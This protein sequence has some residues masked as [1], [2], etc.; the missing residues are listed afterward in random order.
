MLFCLSIGAGGSVSLSE[1][2]SAHEV[3]HAVL[4]QGDHTASFLVVLALPVFGGLIGGVLAVRYRSRNRP[5]STDRLSH[6]LIGLLI[7]GLGV[8]SFLSAV[9]GHVWLSAAGVTVGVATALRFE[10]RETASGADCGNH[11]ELT[12]GAISIHRLLEGI[13]LGTL[14][15][16]G[17]AVGLVGALVLAGHAALETAAVGGLYPTAQRRI[18]V[19][20]AIGLVQAGY[21]VGA[22]ISLGVVGAV[23]VSARTFVLAVVG[24]LL[25]VVGI[26]ET[27]R[28]ITGERPTRTG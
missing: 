22:V 27:E 12:F 21:V 23:P 6:I 17:A 8:V 7:V 5:E 9:V 11:A 14:Y 16:A 15:T 3:G 4:G 24:G 19:L 26:G 28:S 10:N 13:V 2:A 1:T 18:W 25:L 20:G